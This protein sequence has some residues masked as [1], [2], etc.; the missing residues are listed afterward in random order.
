MRKSSALSDVVEVS[1]PAR[2]HIDLI[3]MSGALGRI[4]GSVGL[5]LRNP[6]CHFL[7]SRARLHQ[8]RGL[9]PED[10]KSLVAHIDRTA[11][12][13][14]VRAGVSI[15]V[16]EA[17]PRHSGLGSGTQ[18]E[19]ALLAALNELYGCGLSVGELLTRSSRGR[20]SG[21]GTHAFLCGGFIVDGGRSSGGEEAVF[22]PSRFARPGALPPLIFA[23]R[24][25]P[26]WRVVVYLP[27]ELTGLSGEAERTFMQLNTPVPR[28][29]VAAVCHT[30]LMEMLPALKE[31]E[32]AT[33]ARSVDRIQK[34]GW[35][36]RHWRRPDLEGLAG[37]AARLREAGLQGVGLSSTGPALY[38]FCEVE[39]TG[40]QELLRERLLRSLDGVSRGQLW[41]T[42][43]A[44]SGVEL[45]QHGTPPDAVMAT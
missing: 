40:A 12:A 44:D 13:L 17:I 14:G 37:I 27:E 31:L 19:L 43:G 11:A 9:P 2:L 21:I 1:C 39:S 16:I 29:E 35:K 25:P 7:A 36:A 18:T 3:D 42:S 30:I 34:I 22:A 8:V 10:A 5:A 28:E 20:T 33:F 38:G 45:R 23:A 6:R 24:F 32:L 41:V 15:E 4:N 26:S